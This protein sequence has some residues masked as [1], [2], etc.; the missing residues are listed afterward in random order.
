MKGSDFGN[1]GT[2]ENIVDLLIDKLALSVEADGTVNKVS[3]AMA[4]K[5]KITPALKT[6]MTQITMDEAIQ[7]KPKNEI[8]QTAKVVGFDPK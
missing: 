3:K 8:V 6:R 2:V 5:G 1:A 4:E 7:V